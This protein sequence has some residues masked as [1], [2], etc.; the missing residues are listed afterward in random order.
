MYLLLQLLLPGSLSL[1]AQCTHSNS[2]KYSDLD[3]QWK[4][5]PFSHVQ[6]NC[7]WGSDVQFYPSFQ[8]DVQLYIRRGWNV[9]ILRLDPR[10]IW[11]CEYHASLF[12]HWQSASDILP[13]RFHW[14]SR[15]EDCWTELEPGQPSH[16]SQHRPHCLSLRHPNFVHSCDRVRKHRTI[17]QSIDTSRVARDSEQPS[18]D[19]PLGIPTRYLTR[20]RRIPAPR[21]RP[22]DRT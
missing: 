8:G 16:I 1:R 18:H 15:L 20:V 9:R 2:G 7:E 4:P 5:C 10:P 22:I 11:S 14:K 13:I 3:E 12:V 21:R 17:R 19:S 6:S